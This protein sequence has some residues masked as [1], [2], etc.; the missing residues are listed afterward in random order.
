[1]IKEFAEYLIGVGRLGEKPTLTKLPGR[2]LMITRGDTESIVSEDP[3][4][5]CNAV[6]DVE[7]L[8]DWTHL[9]FLAES[10]LEISVESGKI[11]AVAG[12]EEPGHRECQIP[13]G[14]SPASV[15][16]SQWLQNAWTQRQVVRALRG[17][18][19]GTCN[20]A[21]LQIFRSIDFQRAKQ[22]KAALSH[23]K[24][25]MGRSVESVAQSS[26]GELPEELVFDLTH[27]LIDVPVDPMTVRF[28][29]DVDHETEKFQ[30]SP[31]GTS[32]EEMPRT[33]RRQIANW[34]KSQVDGAT[35]TVGV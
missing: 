2:K 29:L 13:L 14:L 10:P 21:Y 26:A 7:S 34:F 3:P 15:A 23:S 9:E 11:V 5:R 28:A 25:S 1:M 31:I 27:Y 8:L 32:W 24:E 17:P 16:I 33:E 30:I 12:Y 20:P 18:L 22:A 19:Q 35:V 6:A 4:D